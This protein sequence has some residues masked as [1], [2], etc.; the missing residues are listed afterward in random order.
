MPSA[1]GKGPGCDPQGADN[2]GIARPIG[3]DSGWKFIQ[4]CP[5][6]SAMLTPALRKYAKKE[7][8]DVAYFEPFYLK[9]FIATTP[10]KMF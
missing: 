9:Q 7:F 8:E 10:K 2:P 3:N 1:P 6:A 5:E 4:T